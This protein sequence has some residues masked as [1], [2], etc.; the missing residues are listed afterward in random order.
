MYECGKLCGKHGNK[1]RRK[2][3]KKADF[4]TLFF[5]KKIA[6]IVEKKNTI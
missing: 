6:K 3:W 1:K 2:A 4:L 5:L